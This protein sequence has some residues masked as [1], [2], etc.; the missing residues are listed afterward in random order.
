M[1]VTEQDALSF[2]CEVEEVG[3]FLAQGPLLDKVIVKVRASDVPRLKKEYPTLFPPDIYH[4]PD[5]I[6]IFAITLIRGNFNGTGYAK[7]KIY[8]EMTG[9]RVLKIFATN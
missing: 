8:V 3:K 5:A 9:R 7:L 4:N 6:Q 2:A 1:T